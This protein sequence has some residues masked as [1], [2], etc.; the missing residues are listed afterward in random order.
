MLYRE[1][2]SGFVQWTGEAIGGIQHPAWRHYE[3]AWTAADLAAIGLYAPAPADPI[4]EGKISTGQTVQRV[5]GV[6]KYVHTLANIPQPTKAERKEALKARVRAHGMAIRRGGFEVNFG[7]DE[8]PNIQV[9]Q[10]RDA[11]PEND[12]EKNW[13]ASLSAYT[14]AVIGGAGEVQGAK[15]RPESNATIV[16]SYAQAMAVLTGLFDWVASLVQ[17]VWSKCDEIDGAQTHAEL[18]VLEADIESGW[19]G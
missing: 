16:V 11:T 3:A 9:L 19:P 13:M 12:D 10:L 2:S 6:V 14:A 15:F 8:Q 17:T 7:T 5:N 4:P 1:T 18:D